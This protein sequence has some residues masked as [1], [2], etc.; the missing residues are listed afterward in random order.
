MK[1]A[2]SGKLLPDQPT[3]ARLARH[4]G[5]AAWSVIR[6]STPPHACMSHIASYA[7]AAT[8][9]SNGSACLQ[10]ALQAREE[11]DVVVDEEDHA[12]VT[13]LVHWLYSIISARQRLRQTGS[14]A[15]KC[16]RVVGR[17]EAGVSGTT[18]GSLELHRERVRHVDQGEGAPLLGD[19]ATGVVIRHLPSRPP[20]RGGSDR[21]QQMR[22]DLGVGRTEDSISASWIRISR[23][24]R[25]S[26][27][28]AAGTRRQRGGEDEPAHVVQ[29]RR[30]RGVVEHL[31]GSAL[32]GG[33]DA[34]ERAGDIDAVDR[35]AF[36]EKPGTV[37][38]FSY[39]PKA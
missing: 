20:R 11:Q 15:S 35:N 34:R 27:D 26:D 17:V 19:A 38:R 7:P 36:E 6:T 21:P 3:A 30:H 14:R 13:R 24:R 2:V 10:R 39:P 9:T 25:Q 12:G 16:S 4:A 23:L 18:S 8:R 33:D 1:R 32:G 37:W 5:H 29:Q 22:A 31:L 28:G